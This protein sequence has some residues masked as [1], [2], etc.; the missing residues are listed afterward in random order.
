MIFEYR[1]HQLEFDSRYKCP[2]Y[3][4]RSIVEVPWNDFLE[5][6]G[7][8]VRIIVQASPDK[9]P[10][11][12]LFIPRDHAD[13]VVGFHGAEDQSKVD[14]PKFQFANTLGSGRAESFLAISDSTLLY[15]P[16]LTMTWMVGDEETDLAKSYA[17]L[18]NSL[19]DAYKLSRVVLAGHSAGGTA[20]IRIGSMIPDSLAIAVNPQLT[21]ADHR[22]HLSGLLRKHVFPHFQ[23]DSGLLFALRDRLDLRSALEE[24]AEGSRF[25]WYGHEGDRLQFGTH[26]HFSIA[27]DWL[28]LPE[29]GGVSPRGDEMIVCNWHV[30]HGYKHALPGGID[31][32]VREAL[33]EP[34]SLD[35]GI[36]LPV[37]S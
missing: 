3:K 13:L 1:D 17:A 18:I 6:P 33:G 30:P 27:C 32:F 7:K 31:A 26:P 8:K 2:I 9:L 16:E 24:R 36:K 22:P 23:S 29:D 4:Y 14:L 19:V 21:V 20:A 12:A 11:E 10:L 28:N 25:V 34:N 37:G 35:V 15:D 5:Q